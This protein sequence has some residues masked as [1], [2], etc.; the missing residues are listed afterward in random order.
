MAV[1]RVYDS[2]RP[3]G[4]SW[5]RTLFSTNTV[6]LLI[7]VFLILFPH[8]VGWI[9]DSSPFG[10]PRGNTI[11]MTGLSAYWMSV[12]IEIFALSV[13]VMS[14]N[15]MFGFTG[16]ISFGH[17]LFF[18]MGGYL[19]SMSVQFIPLDSPFAQALGI[20]STEGL[21][22][23]GVVAAVIF[24][25]VVGFLMGLVSL[26]LHGIYFAIFTLAVAEMFWIY[27]GRLALTRGED[28]FA[29]SALP[30]I[31]DPARNRLNLYYLG[32][33]LFIATF[34]FI[35]RLVNSPTGS[36]FKAIRENEER[37]QAIGF[38]TLRF[39]LLSITL[40]SIM[41][42]LAGV[43]HIVLAKKVGPEVLG[44]AWTV[45]ALLMTIIGGVGTF[46]GPV[47]GAA[48]LQ[49]ADTLFRDAQ[50]TIGPAVINIGDNWLM[51]TGFIF[52]LVVL[53]FPYGVVGTWNQLRTRL[54]RRNT[55]VEPGKT[56]EPAPAAGD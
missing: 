25:A 54:R 29:I 49:I 27:F 37:A 23:L 10:V 48:G 52:I 31:I 11:R 55:P 12:F 24:S 42:T 44:V 15:L 20:V 8:L 30:E 3:L 34:L 33:V 6:Y 9:T 2:S 40:A 28:G 26:R 53:V 22:V 35:R 16:V 17:A 51:I 14:Y 1:Q 4:F 32:L 41:A 21:F 5:R 43:L 7:L 39:K 38:N 13:L 19:V 47:I 45:D 50:I 36:V 18:G 56:S 46:T